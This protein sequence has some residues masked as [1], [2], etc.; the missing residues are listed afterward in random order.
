MNHGAAQSIWSISASCLAGDFIRSIGMRPWWTAWIGGR[1]NPMER[2]AVDPRW[3]LIHDA[4]PAVRFAI[5]GNKRVPWG[6]LGPGWPK[7]F[8]AAVPFVLGAAFDLP[9]PQGFGRQSAWP[10]GGWAKVGSN[11]PPGILRQP[12]WN[13]SPAAFEASSQVDASRSSS[14]AGLVDFRKP[15][16]WPALADA[17]GGGWQ[18]DVGEQAVLALGLLLCSP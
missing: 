14:R 9:D 1:P 10:W 18:S 17:R 5:L 6:W 7:I 13:R 3:K 2:L 4:A 11:H 15:I 8:W 12:I 16:R